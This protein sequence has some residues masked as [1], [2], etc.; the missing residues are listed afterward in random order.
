MYGKN[1]A[2]A[3]N[4]LTRTLEAKMKALLPHLENKENDEI[5]EQLQ[6]I[7][8]HQYLSENKLDQS[9]LE[10]HH[11]YWH[12]VANTLNKITNE[13]PEK[14]E[15][16]R[17][18]T[19]DYSEQLKENKIRDVNIYNRSIGNKRSANLWF[20][21][22]LGFPI[23]AIGKLLN[24]IPYVSAHTIAKKTAKNIEFFTSVNYASSA[25]I[26]LFYLVAELIIIWNI[27]EIWWILPAYACFKILIGMAAIKY[28]RF[29]K[30]ALGCI[31]TSAM[32]KKNPTFFNEL[33]QKRKEILTNLTGK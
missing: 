22:I 4:E 21:L 24:L 15:H 29:M 32:E 16:L 25:F 19:N 26:S 18:L 8:K 20:T 13:S 12:T 30:P 28:S 5:I 31:R 9:N 11:Q 27:F 17:K 7:Y 3:V 14:A 33:L 1:T 23:Y 6:D 10:N 2:K